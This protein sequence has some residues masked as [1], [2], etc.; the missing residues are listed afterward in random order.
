MDSGLLFETWDGD[1]TTLEEDLTRV[2][3]KHDFEPELA[4]VLEGL[5]MGI[6]AAAGNSADFST[7]AFIEYKKH[8][9][10]TD[11]LKRRY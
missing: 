11:T 7:T 4:V 1:V 6:L 8:L 2:L 10:A 3:L 5:L 9:L